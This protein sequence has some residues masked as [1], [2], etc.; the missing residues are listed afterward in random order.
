MKHLDL[1]IMEDTNDTVPPNPLPILVQSP[2]L[3]TLNA[4]C[5]DLS[6]PEFCQCDCSSLKKLE[7]GM[8]SEATVGQ[9]IGRMPLLE[10]CE[11]TSTSG[12]TA[13]AEP[14]SGAVYP[15]SLR[16]L[17]IWL[18][19]SCPAE[20]WKTLYTPHLTSLSLYVADAAS[21]G[22]LKEI[23][24]SLQ[25]SRA[26]LRELEISSCYVNEA[27]DFIYDHPSITHLTIDKEAEDLEEDYEAYLEGL[28]THL[29]IEQ[30]TEF[31]I[32]GPHLQTLTINIHGTFDPVYSQVFAQDIVEMVKSRAVGASLPPGV[33]ALQTFTFKIYPE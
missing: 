4:Y 1:D 32:L 33:T 24:S 27:I 12:F 26:V 22:T 29:T 16:R 3:E 6:W 14:A 19:H 30:E 8:L 28:V 9:F 10:E 20:A 18:E 11:F 23:S 25:R 2:H 15:S 7:I 21:E 13:D 5:L 31:I 17:I